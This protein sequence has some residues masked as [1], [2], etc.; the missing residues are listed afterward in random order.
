MS[1]WS[2]AAEQFGSTL[3][4][5]KDATTSSLPGFKSSKTNREKTL[6]PQAGFPESRSSDF[7]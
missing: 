3:R 6:L 4:K 5:K 2:F 7:R 1:R